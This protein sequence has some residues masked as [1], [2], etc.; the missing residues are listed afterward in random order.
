MHCSVHL[1]VRCA[2]EIVNAKGQAVIPDTIRKRN[3]YVSGDRFMVV[4][5]SEGLLL[6]RLD[7]QKFYEEFRRICEET[8]RSRAERNG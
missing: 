3:K 7:L 1:R 5:T 8:P 2:H 4:E 6:R